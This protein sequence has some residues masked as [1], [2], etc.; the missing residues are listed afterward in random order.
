MS[1]LIRRKD[2]VDSIERTDWYHINKR[3]ELV[4]G[5]NGEDD[6]PLYKADDVY[7]AIDETPGVETV[8]QKSFAYMDFVEDLIDYIF[9]DDDDYI[10]Y[11]V[12]FRKMYKHGLIDKNAV[13]WCLKGTDD[14]YDR[15]LSERGE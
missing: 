14:E 6:V 7:K 1:D 3:G 13:G 15:L 8:L 10:S 4:H 5:A 9:A 2:A 11:E 12:I